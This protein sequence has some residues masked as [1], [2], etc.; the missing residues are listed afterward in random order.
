MEDVPGWAYNSTKVLEFNEYFEAGIKL[1]QGHWNNIYWTTDKV[2]A[3][4]APDSASEAIMLTDFMI[5]VRPK[6]NL[7]NYLMQPVG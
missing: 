1:Q 4:F 5:E 7:L 3:I 6:P 2:I